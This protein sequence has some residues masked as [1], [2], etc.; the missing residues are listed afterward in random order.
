M[1]LATKSISGD[2]YI[3]DVTK[4]PSVPRNSICSPNYI[5]KG[6]QKEG[7]GLSWSPLQEGYI[8]SG[9]DDQKVCVWDIQNVSA[10]PLRE[11]TEQA[12]I[13]EVDTDDNID[14]RTSAGIPTTAMWLLLAEMTRRSFSMTAVSRTV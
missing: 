4:H 2:V 3:F 12:D 1:L 6:H 9:S 8:A 7:Y 11:Y 5:L 10:M 13:V 14:C